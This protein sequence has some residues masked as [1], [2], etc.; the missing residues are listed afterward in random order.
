MSLQTSFRRKRKAPMSEMNVV[1]YI[2]VMLVLLV[3][4][5]VTAPMLT[6][7]IEVNLPEASSDTL[8]VR[9]QTPLIV[10]V[11]VNGSYSLQDGDRQITVTL[12]SL[13][14]EIRARRSDEHSDVPVLVNGD[15]AVGYGKV[16]ELMAALQAA[17]VKQVGLLTEPPASRQ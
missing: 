14:D 1:P 6:Q 10:S 12:S 11:T 2:D 7:G 5:M 17:G 8:S 3:I 13:P 16:V 15:S 9:D 4:F